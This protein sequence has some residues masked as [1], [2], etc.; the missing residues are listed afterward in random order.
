MWDNPG[1]YETQPNYPQYNIPG[2]VNWDTDTYQDNPS[3]WYNNSNTNYYGTNTGPGYIYVDPQTNHGQNTTS[4]SSGNLV[5][6]KSQQ[7]PKMLMVIPSIS[8]INTQIHNSASPVIHTLLASHHAH[9]RMNS[10]IG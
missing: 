8:V 6:R 1:Y 4:Y 9:G 3:W 2:N 10:E 7:V 5:Y